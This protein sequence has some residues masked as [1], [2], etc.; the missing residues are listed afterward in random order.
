MES[1]RKHELV[2]LVMVF[3]SGTLLGFGLYIT[4]WGANR[5]LFYNTID[6]LIKGKEFLLFPLFYGFSF[7]LMA[8]GMIELKEMKPGRRR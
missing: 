8:L 6:A 3:L 5:P 2:G 4:F 7:L 1:V